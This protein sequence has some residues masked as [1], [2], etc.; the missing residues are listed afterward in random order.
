MTRPEA[1]VAVILSGTDDPWFQLPPI[2]RF[3]KA[4]P[5]LLRGSDLGPDDPLR[6]KLVIYRRVSRLLGWTALVVVAALTVVAQVIR[7]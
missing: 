6:R 7:I 1:L 5:A 2:V 3:V 4:A